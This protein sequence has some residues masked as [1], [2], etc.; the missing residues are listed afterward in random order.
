[1]LD[2]EAKEIRK[3]FSGPLVALAELK[4]L[5]HNK[6]THNKYLPKRGGQELSMNC[7]LKLLASNYCAA[8]IKA[9]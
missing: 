6:R 2:I 4:L 8:Q 7:F 9:R 1:M 3:S 5:T